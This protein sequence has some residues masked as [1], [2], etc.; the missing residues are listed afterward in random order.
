LQDEHG[1][2]QETE[3]ASADHKRH[4]DRG[5][6]RETLAQEP[7][8]QQNAGS[9]EQDQNADEKNQ[10]RRLESTSERPDHDQSH[11]DKQHD[12]NVEQPQTVR[13]TGRARVF[14]VL[15]EERRTSIEDSPNR[16]SDEIT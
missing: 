6:A 16:A 11:H 4:R 3:E 7:V 9:H 8:R 5:R 15:A 13:Q 14:A 12:P 2:A 1:D 10:W